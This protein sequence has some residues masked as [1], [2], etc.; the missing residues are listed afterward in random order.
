MCVRMHACIYVYAFVYM[1]VRVCDD[2]M[3]VRERMCVYACMH[4]MCV[5]IQ[6]Q[7]VSQR[8]YSCLAYQMVSGSRGS[9]KHHII[10]TMS[11]CVRLYMHVQYICVCLYNA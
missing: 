11:V 2:A 6:Y 3:H 7:P 4:N 9:L 8:F 1:H 10:H 5:C